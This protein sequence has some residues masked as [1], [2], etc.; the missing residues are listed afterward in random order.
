MK[1]DIINIT[2]NGRKDTKHIYTIEA[3]IYG[4]QEM[5]NNGQTKLA[6]ETISK[7]IT[8]FFAEK[9]SSN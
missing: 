1:N 3:D 9:I 4:I 8:D 2:D 7:T 6:I 5:I